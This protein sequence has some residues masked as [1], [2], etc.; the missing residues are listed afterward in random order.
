MMVQI[1]PVQ[2]KYLIIDISHG[3]CV[4]DHVHHEDIFQSMDNST[5]GVGSIIGVE[6]KKYVVHNVFISQSGN[7]T[8]EVS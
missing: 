3:A 4:V 7:V 2:T 5:L 1:A 8:L 6:G